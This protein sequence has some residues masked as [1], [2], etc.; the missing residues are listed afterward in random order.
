[1]PKF[2]L[3]AI[4]RSGNKKPSDL[5][6][7]VDGASRTWSAGRRAWRPWRERCARQTRVGGAVPAASGGRRKRAEYEA[8]H[9]RWRL[10]EHDH[11]RELLR[12]Q[13]QLQRVRHPFGIDV[14]LTREPEQR[15][16]HV[17]KALARRHL[18]AHDG[19]G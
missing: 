18:H 15:L 1:M 16:D 6:G 9:S 19:V 4:R 10:A 17:Y 7:F 11:V 14:P 12:G 2:D 5:E 3:T 13:R 8:L